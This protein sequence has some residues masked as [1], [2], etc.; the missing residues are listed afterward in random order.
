MG[1]KISVASWLIGTIIK[2]KLDDS[3]SLI[4]KYRGYNKGSVLV[5]KGESNKDDKNVDL[6]S[7]NYIVEPLHNLSSLNDENDNTIKDTHNPYMKK[8]TAHMHGTCYNLN[9]SDFTSNIHNCDK[10]KLASKSFNSIGIGGQC[11]GTYFLS[12]GVAITLCAYFDK[13][14]LYALN[15]NTLRVISS[16]QLPGRKGDLL[17]AITLNFYKLSHN[18]SG[19][20]YFYLDNKENIIIGCADNVVRKISFHNNKFSLLNEIDMNKHLVSIV[21]L[22]PDYNGNLWVIDRKGNIIVWSLNNNTLISKISL[23]EN[24]ENS[25]GISTDK[26]YI[27]T[28]NHLYSYDAKEF[29]PVW[30]NSYQRVSYNKPGTISIGS[31]STPTIL[32]NYV[33]ITDNSE[34]Q[35]NAN[36]Y[37][38]SDGHLQYSVSVPFSPYHGANECSVVGLSDS[39]II[40]VNTY[41]YSSFDQVHANGDRP[42]P[43]VCLINIS[44]DYRNNDYIQW[45]SYECPSTSLPLVDKDLQ[46]LYLYTMD[47]EDSKKIPTF[48]VTIIDTNTGKTLRKIK[49]GS[50]IGYDNHWSPL[51][52]GPDGSA[53]IGTLNGIVK[54]S[55]I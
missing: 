14:Q 46:R 8:G 47:L 13:F 49:T 29:S 38:I 36:F 6:R 35:I 55:S 33:V 25:F 7:S 42:T 44:E 1:N 48:S 31:G 52:L 53:Y 27:L 3:D 32:D 23:N 18:T 51:H 43:G 50:G 12:N 9:V 22:L 11:V 41:G 37:R 28:E 21:S 54:I 19:G 5:F 45:V 24:I 30:M 15:P 16:Y 40:V 26:V 2:K 39:Q 20:A 17:S 34:Y 4:T 10:I